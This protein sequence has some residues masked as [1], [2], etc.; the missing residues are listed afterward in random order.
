MKKLYS[1][2][3]DDAEHC[4]KTGSTQVHIHHVFY[5]PYR[6]KS[7]KYGFIVPLVYYLHE[8]EWGSVHNN[9][10]TGLDLELKQLAQTY[11]EEHIGTREQFRCEFG[12]SWL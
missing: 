3:T 10:N 9:P 4:I 2:L 8:F 7:E 12:K 1:A 6:K 11:F 5:G